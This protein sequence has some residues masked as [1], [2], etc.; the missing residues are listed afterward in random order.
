MRLAQQDDTRTLPI[1]VY[2]R[3]YWSKWAED[4]RG[5]SFNTS[6]VFEISGQLDTQA[7]RRA[8]EFVIRKHDIMHARF[9]RDGSTQYYADF[10]FADFFTERRGARTVPLDAELAQ[11]LNA[12]FDLTTGPLVRCHLLERDGRH[13][14]VGMAHH[15]IADAV[16]ARILISDLV[17][18]YAA[19]RQDPA[20]PAPQRY[21]YAECIEALHASHTPDRQRAARE[22]WTAFLADTPLVVDFPR[23]AE[24][25]EDQSAESLYFDI[26]ETTTRHLKAF[27]RDNRTTLFT[28]L[29]ALY[30]FLLSR[31]AS[32]QTVV[33]SYPV[34][35]R[36]PGYDHVFGCFVN[37]SLLKVAIDAGTTFPGLVG[38]L[39]RQ[40]GAARPHLFYQLSNIIHGQGAVR[41][42]IEKSYFGVFFGETHLN[43]QPLD[44]GE[45]RVRALDVPWSQQFD[46]D[47]RLLYDAQATARIKFRMD[48]RVTRY[49]GAL[50]RRFI[51][52]FTRLAQRIAEDPGPLHLLP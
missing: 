42:D 50:I 19:V 48:Y 9:S 32:Q 23:T 5:S 17:L 6:L 31:Y 40:R 18:A 25:T 35:M 3:R 36:P 14:F 44:L 28:V 27:A 30:G 2:Q 46:R 47:L 16:A 43:N 52:D 41:A 13:Y 10:A 34:N 4:P 33:L 37:L 12:P 45:L 51:N 20:G 1:S 15:I 39:T 22:F 24:P 7:L 49:D 26:D 29:G 11:I 38:E 21:S 8:C